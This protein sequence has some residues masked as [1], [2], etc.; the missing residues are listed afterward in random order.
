MSKKDKLNKLNTRNVNKKL[1][2]KKVLNNRL[3]SENK[4][5]KYKLAG[6]LGYLKEQATKLQ[7]CIAENGI[8]KKKIC[9]YKA[10]TR[11]LEGDKE[12]K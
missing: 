2:K 9:Y 6:N 8:L 7:K 4:E 11:K 5:L 3:K 10:K 1:N 12:K